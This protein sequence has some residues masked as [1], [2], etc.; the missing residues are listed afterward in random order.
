MVFGQNVRTSENSP[1]IATVAAFFLT[2]QE[3][4][5]R[6]FDSLTSDCFS[7]CVGTHHFPSQGEWCYCKAVHLQFLQNFVQN[8]RVVTWLM[9][10]N[11]FS[12]F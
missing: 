8:A 9:S 7:K 3:I 11:I 5:G 10:Q 4:L 6:I 1:E 2:K 12:H